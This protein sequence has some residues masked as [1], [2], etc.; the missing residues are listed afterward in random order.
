MASEALNMIVQKVTPCGI[1]VLLAAAGASAQQ[2]QTY[3]GPN[4]P[5]PGSSAPAA[6]TANPYA[7]VNLYPAANPYSGANPYRT[8]SPDPAAN[9]YPA[10]NP[11]APASREVMNGFAASG[12]ANLSGPSS[13]YPVKQAAAV[14]DLP[15]PSSTFAA[16]Q[17]SHSE[18][19]C[20]QCD[21]GSCDACQAAAGDGSRL[22]FT[23][24]SAT[25]AFRGPPD[26]AFSGNFG[27]VTGLNAAAPI[28]ESWG[29]GWQ[30]GASYGVYDFAGRPSPALNQ[31]GAQQQIFVITGFFRRAAEGE[32]LSF[33]VVHDWMVNN[34]Y[35]QYA[36]SPTLSQWRGQ[37]EWAMSGINSLGI[38]ATVHDRTY[39]GDRP[40]NHNQFRGINQIN[41]FWHHKYQYGGD[42]WFYV[43]VPD[44]K[45]LAGSGL[46]G[47]VLLGGSAQVPLTERVS[48]YAQGVYMPPNASPG[49]NGS[50]RD[51]YNI[52]VGLAWFPGRN[53]RTRTVNGARWLPYMPLGNNSNFLVDA[54]HFD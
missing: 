32:R 13:Q 5:L 25:D 10:A 17:V 35:G 15:S 41:L 11:Y 49:P 52:G 21:D 47:S 50:S 14:S 12:G 37:L 1:L 27:S 16:Q 53:A 26:G 46:A 34:N 23:A 9:F 22:G 38:W 48:L 30:L 20:T 7:D 33:G 42:T 43:G 36:L 24:F 39:I 3:A 2:P 29:L 6:N 44:S 45:R 19:S 8:E 31:R 4:S 54:A 18:P 28:V 51:A 40:D